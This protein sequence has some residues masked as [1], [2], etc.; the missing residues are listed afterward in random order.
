M[1]I[2]IVYHLLPPIEQERNFKVRFCRRLVQEGEMEITIMQGFNSEEKV[3]WGESREA[4]AA[5]NGCWRSSDYCGSHSWLLVISEGGNKN[6]A[7]SGLASAVGGI[8]QRLQ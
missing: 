2:P 6:N 1:C 7:S 3:W 5:K 8:F 4:A